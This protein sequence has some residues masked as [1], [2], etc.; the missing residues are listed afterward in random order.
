[1][2]AMS[3]LWYW[4]SCCCELHSKKSYTY[5]V[6]RWAPRASLLFND[7][8]SFGCRAATATPFTR[9]QHSPR[10]IICTSSSFLHNPPIH[11]I[12]L[13]S[14]PRRSPGHPSTRLPP[15]PTSSPPRFTVHA[16]FRRYWPR[17]TRSIGRFT[18]RCGIDRS[19]SRRCPR[20]KSKAV[21]RAHAEI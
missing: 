11:N 3:L 4:S 15:Y 6:S 1:M 9:R 5:F 20:L 14:Q 13:Q 7:A 17:L 8:D 10:H 12:L 19:S 16:P 21:P 2:V 18:D